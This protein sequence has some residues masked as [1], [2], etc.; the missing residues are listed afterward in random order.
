MSAATTWDRWSATLGKAGDSGQPK[1]GSAAAPSPR[2]RS[3]SAGNSV[4]VLCS[5]LQLQH[6]GFG[7]SD[8][9]QADVLGAVCVYHA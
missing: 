6:R 1:S 9:H 8:F 2:F 4:P 5:S 7:D 3:R